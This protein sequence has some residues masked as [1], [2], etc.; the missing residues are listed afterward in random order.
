MPE[1]ATSEEKYDGWRMLA[2][3]DGLRVRQPAGRRPHRVATGTAAREAPALVHARPI[4][5]ISPGKTPA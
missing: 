5:S 4:G 1:I 2:F 3:T